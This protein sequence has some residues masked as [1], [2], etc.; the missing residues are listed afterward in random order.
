MSNSLKQIDWNGFDTEWETHDEWSRLENKCHDER[1]IC[2]CPGHPTRCSDLIMNLSNT[3]YVCP[4]EVRN[5]MYWYSQ[6]HS[7]PYNNLIRWMIEGSGWAR[8]REF[9]IKEG[10]GYNHIKDLNIVTNTRIDKDGKWSIPFTIYISASEYNNFSYEDKD[11][12]HG[13]KRSVY[14][15]LCD[16]CFEPRNYCIEFCKNKE[17]VEIMKSYVAQQKDHALCDEI[18]GWAKAKIF[19]SRPLYRVNFNGL[20]REERM[21]TLASLFLKTIAKERDKKWKKLKAIQKK[22]SQ[23]KEL[24]LASEMPSSTK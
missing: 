2:N 10:V 21:A 13:C 3:R 14:D 7:Y 9:L 8:G 15:D 24:P 1:Y 6:K 16:F 18:L 5:I 22:Q 17:Q 11:R 23:W 19:N 4:T 12:C 20:S